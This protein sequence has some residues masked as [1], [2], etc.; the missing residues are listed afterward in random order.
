MGR[1]LKY[2]TL[3]YLALL[4]ILCLQAAHSSDFKSPEIFILGDSQLQ[5][6]SGPAF[7]DFF[8]NI[9]KHCGSYRYFNE[10]TQSL[11]NAPTGVLGVGS[12]SLN[13]W[14]GRDDASKKR[15][16][17]DNPKWVL[18]AST[19]G[20]LKYTD[21]NFLEIG[22]KEPF[23]F[24]KQ[25]RSAFEMMFDNKYYDPK[26]F[27]M[28]FLGNSSKRWAASVD[29]ARE[30][31]IQAMQQIPAGMPCVFMT[32]AP[33][34][35]QRMIEKRYNGQNNLRK[36]F[37]YVGSRC[38]FVSGLTPETINVNVAN[39]SN[40]KFNKK[41]GKVKDPFHPNA[42]AAKTFLKLKRENICRAVLEQFKIKRGHDRSHTFPKG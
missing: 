6:G 8:S 16:C 18:N 39:D 30:D 11:K 15:I 29:N 35:H 28:F 24:C 31:V 7:Q 26:L 13:S 12:T 3:I 9:H 17:T 37:Q 4:N 14:T 25:D 19:F 40:F 33:P 41:T 27:V 1:L 32:T 34:Y 42:N 10:A 5:F 38:S 22:Q 21:K 23:N 20:T 36:A 2:R